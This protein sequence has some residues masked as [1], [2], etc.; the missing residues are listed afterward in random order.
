M[1]QAE[2]MNLL[3]ESRAA[4]LSHNW[5]AL[6][7]LGVMRLES[8][9]ESGAESAWTESLALRPSVWALRNLAALSLRRED[10]P[11]ALDCYT[12]AWQLGRQQGTLPAALAVETLQAFL[13]AGR[14]ADGLQF[15]AA[16]PSEVMWT[17]R[18]QVLLGRLALAA[19]DLDTVERV[20]ERDYAVMR[21]G[22]AS[23][24]DLWIEL[25]AR[26]LAQSTGRPLDDDL[27]AQA[28]RDFPPP[29]KIDFRS[30]D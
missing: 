25:H 18:V 4:G 16:L 6:L 12:R 17:D 15:Y 28:A 23:L 5:Y 14:V 13:L 21:E 1:V 29:Q 20:L 2:W 8:G 11:A 27:R 22:E 9:D 26:R 30:A 3:A 7:H 19:G 10:L 24:V